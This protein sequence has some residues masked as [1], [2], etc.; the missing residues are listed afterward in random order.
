MK[1]FLKLKER[2]KTNEGFRNRAYKD[3]LGFYTIGYGHLIK[4]N[5]RYLLKKKFS[6]QHLSDLF[7]LD[8]SKAV[9]SYKKIYQGIGHSTNTQ[10]VLIEM[11]FQLGPKK[12]IKFKKMNK[13]IRKKEFFMAALE[14]KQSLWYKQ[15]P[16]RVDGLITILLQK[17]Y[18]KKR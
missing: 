18:G 15:T 2:I 6:K 4:K 8:F 9:K 10:D 13:N 3:S 12:L 5:Q 17:D 16:K 11:I 1:N 7:D 14:M